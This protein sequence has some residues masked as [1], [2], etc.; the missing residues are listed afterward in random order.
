MASWEFFFCL[1][2][3]HVERFGKTLYVKEFLIIWLDRGKNKIKFEIEQLIACMK[4]QI[5][6]AFK[7]FIYFVHTFQMQKKKK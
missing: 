4:H 1:S 2:Y 3:L 5:L 6:E 7:P